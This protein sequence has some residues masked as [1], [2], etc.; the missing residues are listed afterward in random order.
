[1]PA[2]AGASCCCTKNAPRKAGG[3]FCRYPFTII[4]HAGMSTGA[5][6][7]LRLKI[8]P[9]SKTTGLAL[10]DGFRLIW[11]AELQHRGQRMKASLDARRAVRRSRR[12]RHT[13]YRQPR[14]DN[15]TRPAGWLPPSLW[16]RVCNVMTWVERLTR[17]CH[18]TA[19]SQELVRFDMQLMQDAVVSGVAYQQGELAGYEVREYLLEKWHRTCAYCGAQHVPLQVEHIIPKARGGAAPRVQPHAGLRALQPEERHANGRRVRLSAGPGA[20]E[21]VLEGRRRCQCHWWALYA[22]LCATGLPVECGTGGRTKY[23]RTRLG[24]SKSHWGDAACVGA[25]TPE[26]LDVA[27]AQP[28]GIR[29]IGHGCRQRCRTDAYGFPTRHVAGRKRHFGFQTGDI[30]RAT[31]PCGK[32][33]GTHVGRVTVRARGSFNLSG[34]DINVQ[35]VRLL[36]VQTA[37]TTAS[38]PSNQTR[39]VLAGV[40]REGTDGTSNPRPI[41][42][43]GPRS[44]PAS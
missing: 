28:L 7:P 27:G 15:R 25:S 2:Q 21:A 8:D 19:L 39:G 34:K 44:P 16:S 11:A 33:A 3:C 23:N 43:P 32:Y 31:V 20:G 17:Y 40:P 9:G 10:L 29:A 41:D 38:R 36:T 13:R 37:M 42:A 24:I 5:P 14:F 22:Q 18:I 35:Y 30:V 4:C 1:M 26:A 6:L 12:Q